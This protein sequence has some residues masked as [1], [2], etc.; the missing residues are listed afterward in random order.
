MFNK[1]WFFKKCNF[2]PFNQEEFPF[3]NIEQQ[4][5]NQN[6]HREALTFHAA[7]WVPLK[8]PLLEP[9]HFSVIRSEFL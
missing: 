5:Y 9:D 1:L 4:Q 2:F 6:Q 7:S 8:S 3:W